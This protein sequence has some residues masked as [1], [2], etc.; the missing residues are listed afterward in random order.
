MRQLSQ[1]K[2]ISTSVVQQSIP[3]LM[4]EIGHTPDPS[5]GVRIDADLTAITY[6]VGDYADDG[7]AKRTKRESVFAQTWP[8]EVK[9]AVETL[10]AW[11]DSHAE[12]H[13]LV[14]A[15]TRRKDLE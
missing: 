5:G 11:A 10:L 6:V 15:G 9:D 1:P 4:I 2:V 3:R 13:N 12:A 14:E 7:T 8:D